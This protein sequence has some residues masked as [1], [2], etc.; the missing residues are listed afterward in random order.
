LYISCLFLFTNSQKAD[1]K[2]LSFILLFMLP[3]SLFDYVIKM[4]FY[5]NANTSKIFIIIKFLYVAL[6]IAIFAIYKMG[7]VDDC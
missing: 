1:I 4:A 3:Y 7:Y 5:A 2:G 6:S